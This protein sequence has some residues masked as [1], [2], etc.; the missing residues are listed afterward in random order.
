VAGSLQ[1]TSEG[2]RGGKAIKAQAQHRTVVVTFGERRKDAA[3]GPAG[4]GARHTLLDNDDIT[5]PASEGA[6][7]GGSDETCSN[8]DDAHVQS[9]AGC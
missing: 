7:D 2:A 5:S 4:L 9:L 3:G 6:G 1:L 8:D